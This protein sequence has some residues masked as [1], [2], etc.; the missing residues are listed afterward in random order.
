M[1]EAMRLTPLRW[2]EAVR[3]TAE[4][5]IESARQAQD[6]EHAADRLQFSALDVRALIAQV[7][8]P[9]TMCFRGNYDPI[10]PVTTG[11]MDVRR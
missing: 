9:H 6:S 1:H 8:T 5:V 10:R 3:R 4:S 2:M 11:Q 7:G